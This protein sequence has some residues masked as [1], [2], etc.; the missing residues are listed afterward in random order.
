MS[1][2]QSRPV[3]LWFHNQTANKLSCQSYG[4]WE[5]C[6]DS[7]ADIFHSRS[8]SLRKMEWRIGSDVSLGRLHRSFPGCQIRILAGI[9]PTSLLSGTEVEGTSPSATFQGAAYCARFIRDNSP[10]FARWEL[11][12]QSCLGSLCRKEESPPRE[13][14]LRSDFSRGCGKK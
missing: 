2:A 5:S 10:T 12:Q 3:W 9:A 1:R 14:P 11:R 4:W 8:L 7:S 6:Q 13:H